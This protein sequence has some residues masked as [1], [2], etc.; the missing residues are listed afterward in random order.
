MS[1]VPSLERSILLAPDRV[2]RAAARAAPD[3]RARWMLLQPRAV[4]ESF[5]REAWNR[6]D[7]A[8]EV[9]MLRQPDA[10][11]ESYVA[12]VLEAEPPR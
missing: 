5:V 1:S 8:E 9:W 4:R 11:R 2:A 6:G 12:E 10:V 3:A 7:R